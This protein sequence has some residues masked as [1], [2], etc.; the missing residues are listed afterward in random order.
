MTYSILKSESS[1]R[2]HWSQGR[3]QVEH[4]SPGLPGSRGGDPALSNVERAA[5]ILRSARAEMDACANRL[6]ELVNSRGKSYKLVRRRLVA[7]RRLVDSAI[8]DLRPVGATDWP[9]DL[10]LVRFRRDLESSLKSSDIAR[11]AALAQGG[12][13]NRPSRKRRQAA[14][15]ERVQRIAR[16]LSAAARREQARASAEPIQE[17]SS[18]ARA[19]SRSIDKRYS[20][21]AAIMNVRYRTDR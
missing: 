19:Q 17:E 18:V 12:V 1:P 14:D 3:K 8:A 4:G 20:G 15:R 11:S 5:Q 7:L 16:D 9:I 2:F 6:A 13:A 21:G 10:D